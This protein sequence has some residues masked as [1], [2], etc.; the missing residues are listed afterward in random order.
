MPRGHPG[1]RRRR[2]QS[3]RIRRGRRN[4]RRRH[5]GGGGALIRQQHTGAQLAEQQQRIGVVRPP[6]CPQMQARPCITV[7]AAVRSH[8]KLP[9]DVAGS[10]SVA[11]RHHR[12]DRLIRR[13]QTIR[14]HHRHYGPARDLAGKVHCSVLNSLDSS[15]V[16]GGDV[17]ASMPRPVL[18]RRRLEDTHHRMRGRERP[19]PACIRCSHRGG[20]RH[21]EQREH[22]KYRHEQ[23]TDSEARAPW[24]S[25]GVLAQSSHS[26]TVRGDCAP[27]QRTI[28]AVDNPRWGGRGAGAPAQRGTPACHVRCAELPPDAMAQRGMS[29]RDVRQRAAARPVS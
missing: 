26:S 14:M 15:A 23:H 21:R 29:Q 28:T 18:M 7:R 10:H 12:D 27:H 11:R 5:A 1:I 8:P 19:L 9:D 3:R 16:G 2:G 4:G 6:T 13:E 24:R 22:G 20:S 25:S 17:N